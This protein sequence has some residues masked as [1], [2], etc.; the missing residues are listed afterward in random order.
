MKTHLKDAMLK[1]LESTLGIVSPAVK[2]VGIDRGTHYNWMENDEE[3]K[4][5]VTEIQNVTLDFAETK[6]MELIKDG[7]PS[8]VYFYLKTKGQGRGYI[9]RQQTD[10]N[11]KNEMNITLNLD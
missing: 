5:R 9:E 10:L 6:L 11:V 3:Y 1:A 8:A 2:M 7:E 4:K